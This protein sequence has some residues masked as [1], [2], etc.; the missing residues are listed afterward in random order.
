M[1]PL[2]LKDKV[3][4]ILQERKTEKLTVVDVAKQTQIAD[5]MI[6][7]SAQ[8]NMQVRS[9]CEFIDD[10]LDKEYGIVP[11]RREGEKEGRWIVMDYSSVII[12]IFKNE[13]RDTYS[14]EKLWTCG[15]NITV[16]EQ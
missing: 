8:T 13:L 3:I 10:K 2:E 14:L 16:I 5:Y 7:M 9:L 1:T 4:E 6:I 12:H 15:D 11:K